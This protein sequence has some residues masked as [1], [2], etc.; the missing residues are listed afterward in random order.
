MPL[1]T[2]VLINY[3]VVSHCREKYVVSNT[4]VNNYIWELESCPYFTFTCIFTSKSIQHSKTKREYST[5]KPHLLVRN[6]CNKDN[7]R[8]MQNIHLGMHVLTECYFL[9]FFFSVVAERD[10]LAISKSPYIVNLFYSFQSKDR[11]FLVSSITC[12]NLCF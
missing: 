11:I 9:C 8:D 1:N 5:T 2:G 6:D 3:C 4:M 10:A 7:T 12:I